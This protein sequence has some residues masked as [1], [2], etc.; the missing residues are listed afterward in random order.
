[1]MDAEYIINILEKEEDRL[2]DTLNST[3]PKEIINDVMAYVAIKTN[4]VKLKEEL[5][6]ITGVYDGMY[7]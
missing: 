3:I 4:I 7:S 1:M 2:Y 5:N 6:R